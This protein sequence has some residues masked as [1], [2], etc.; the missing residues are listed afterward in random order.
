MCIRDRS[1]RTGDMIYEAYTTS[2]YIGG[3]VG[4]NTGTVSDLSLIH[5]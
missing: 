3:I 2:L 5:I 1:K 4:G